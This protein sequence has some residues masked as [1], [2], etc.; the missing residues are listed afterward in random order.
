MKYDDN[1]LDKFIKDR[2][3]LIEPTPARDPAIAWRTRDKYLRKIN[4]LRMGKPVRSKINRVKKKTWISNLR[5]PRS[6]VPFAVSIFLLI[7]MIFGSWGTVYA[8]QDSL[9]NEP[10]YSIKLMGENLQLSLTSNTIARISLL[11][12]FAN[13][14]A[15]E[16]SILASQGEP[17]PE[18][19]STLID[20][21]R[22]EITTL[23]AS[24]DEATVLGEPPDV[25]IY[26]RPQDRD[27][28]GELSGSPDPKMY[29]KGQPDKGLEDQSTTTMEMDAADLTTTITGTLEVSSTLHITPTRNGPGYGPGYCKE[30]GDCTIPVEEHSP[31]PYE[32]KPPEPEDNEGY[33]P[34]AD[35]GSGPLQPIAPQPPEASEKPKQSPMTDSNTKGNTP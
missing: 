33:G 17:I 32:G 34:G 16:S 25:G 4:Y 30:L 23:T 6:L 2:L 20:K 3:K 27:K 19:L 10:L 14:R 21:Y 18:K 1:E 22:E 35:Q 7:G 26:Q 29:L 24:L 13:R 31:G 5:Q 15:D 9:P 28:D 12:T 11:T 8:A